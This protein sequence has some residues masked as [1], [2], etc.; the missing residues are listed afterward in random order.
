M[1]IPHPG[2]PALTKVFHKPAI[3]AT[4]KANATVRKKTPAI[5]P[6]GL[7]SLSWSSKAGKTER[8]NSIGT[9][10]GIFG[11]SYITRVGKLLQNRVDVR[12]SPV[13]AVTGWAMREAV[14]SLID[15]W[16]HPFRHPL[17]VDD[18][19]QCIAFDA[20]RKNLEVFQAVRGDYLPQ[21]RLP[22]V[23]LDKEQAIYLP[24]ARR[25]R[26]IARENNAIFRQGYL[27]D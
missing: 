19:E 3:T 20:P 6:R 4:V 16:R 13:N 27:H 18:I 8:I 2:W 10:F 5:V 11:A 17:F 24:A 21:L 15:V 9:P 22:V 26:D 7:E 12:S 23:M 14:L 1:K 25:K